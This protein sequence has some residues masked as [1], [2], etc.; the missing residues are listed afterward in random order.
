MKAE[1][2]CDGCRQHREHKYF[3]EWI[4]SASTE[5]R[6][7]NMCRLS[8]RTGNDGAFEDKLKAKKAM[9]DER[10]SKLTPVQ[11]NYSVS[12]SAK[13]KLKTR[14]N[15][16]DILEQRKLNGELEL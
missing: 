12:D 16:E 10:A 6:R 4:I 5:A 13:A 1:L 9:A 11:L 2:Y 7:C 3:S 15:I 8:I 14:R